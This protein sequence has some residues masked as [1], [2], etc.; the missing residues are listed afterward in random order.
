M[1][2]TKSAVYTGKAITPAV[3]VTCGKRTLTAGKD[4][5]VAY[6]SN[7]DFGKAK[8]VIMGIGNY[9][10]TQT[11][12]FDITAA[13]GKIYANGNYKYKITNASLNGKER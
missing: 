9:S 11:K 13:V 10:G 8:V 1:T 12:Y 3:K 5:R 4:Y 7:K 6:S 2:I